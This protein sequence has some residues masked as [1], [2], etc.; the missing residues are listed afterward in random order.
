MKYLSVIIIFLCTF[1]ASAQTILSDSARISLM[2]VAPGNEVYSL[3]GHSAIRVYDAEKKINRCYN[4][5]TFEFD[6]PNFL[7]KFCR[8]K[9]LYYLNPEPYKAFE[10]ANLQDGRPMKEQVF[11]FNQEQKQRLYQLLEENAKE[12]NRFYKYDFFYDNC[13]TRIREILK[14]TFYH[15]LYYDSTDLKSGVTMRDLLQPYLENHAW[16]RFGIDLVLGQPCDKKATAEDYMFLP[17]HLHDFLAKTKIKANLPIV[18]AN[19]NIPEDSGNFRNIPEI[20]NDPFD[21]FFANPL[22]VTCFIALIGLLSMANP[23]T[24]RI[25]DTIFWFVLG[26]AGLIMTL[27][28]FATD[29]IAT[30]QNWNIL[31]A[32]PTHLLFF[33]RSKKS[34]TTQNYFTGVAILAA[35][36]LAFWKF[37]PQ[38]MPIAAIP[39]AALVVIKGMWR[40]F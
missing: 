30:K 36:A 35:L 14:E 15:Q 23:R 6:Q 1:N 20:N 32:L 26:I 34:E 39:I 18:K 28:W 11:N 3:F 17:D 27:L 25:F 2:T 9:L 10:N 31:W 21:R 12:A 16:T 5:G 19:K 29:H 24:E 22:W 13:S 33:W 7:M 4:Y 40:R 8:G 38:A 37:C